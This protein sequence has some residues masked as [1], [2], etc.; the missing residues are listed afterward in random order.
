MSLEILQCSGQDTIGVTDITCAVWR[1]KKC[2]L[3]A[4]NPVSSTRTAA[5]EVSN[6]LLHICMQ[7]WGSVANHQELHEAKQQFWIPSTDPFIP[8]VL[9][10]KAGGMLTLQC[11]LNLP[12][13]ILST[14]LT[15]PSAWA[16]F[17]HS[18]FDSISSTIQHATF[19]LV[20]KGDPLVNTTNEYSKMPVK[21]KAADSHGWC[22]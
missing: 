10:R 8:Q 7:L 16:G 22:L 14:H 1:S 12:Q 11:C 2:G 17:A 13:N 6:C 19:C 9:D 20:G 4:L 3:C 5:E 18:L 21:I 15:W